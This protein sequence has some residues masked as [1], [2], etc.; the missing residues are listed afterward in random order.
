[1]HS[2]SAHTFLQS[3]IKIRNGKSES[4][5]DDIENEMYEDQWK[6][7]PFN[8]TNQ[9]KILFSNSSIDY[10]NVQSYDAISSN[11]SLNSK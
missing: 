3:R 4:R 1:M 10:A 8:K 7:N 11:H 6:K 9:N 5:G 2:T